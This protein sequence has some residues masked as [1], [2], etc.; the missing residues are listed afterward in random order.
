MNNSPSS[1][2]RF[3][4]VVKQLRGA[5]VNE[6]RV[7][8]N[9]EKKAGKPVFEKDHRSTPANDTPADEFDSGNGVSQYAGQNVEHLNNGSGGLR[10]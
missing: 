9:S 7:I 1:R 6:L 5:A 8:D 2:N 3:N 4:P 10:R